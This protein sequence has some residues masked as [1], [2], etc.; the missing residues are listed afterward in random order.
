[1]PTA[2]YANKVAKHRFGLDRF[3]QS[4]QVGVYRWLVLSLIAFVLAMWGCF[5]MEMTTIP[6]WGIAAAVALEH[7]FPLVALT[8]LIQDI[9][10][11]RPLARQ[12]GLD[13]QIS[14][15]KI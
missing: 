4:T 15:C 8:I 1:M 9:E 14:W 13:I 7:F 2:G 6:D 3:G 11:L 5:L 12:H 10:R